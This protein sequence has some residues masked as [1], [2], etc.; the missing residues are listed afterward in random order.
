MP[1]ERVVAK[2]VAHERHQAVGPLAPVD[3]LRR[4]EEPHARRKAQH[5][6]AVR[7]HLE[8]PRESRRVERRRHADYD[9]RAERDLEGRRFVADEQAWVEYQNSDVNPVATVFAKRFP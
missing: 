3:G 6:P 1:A 9:P 7:E 8:Q 2:H 4:D 5:A